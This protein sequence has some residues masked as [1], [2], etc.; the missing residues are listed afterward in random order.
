MEGCNVRLKFGQTRAESLVFVH[1][2]LHLLLKQRF[3]RLRLLSIDS[4]CANLRLR[5]A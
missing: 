5:S 1:D 4:Q 3:V 2:R